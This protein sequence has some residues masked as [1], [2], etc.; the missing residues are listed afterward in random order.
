MQLV[1]I[2]THL[3]EAFEEVKKEVIEMLNSQNTNGF[4][5][6]SY[7]VDGVYKLRRANLTAEQTAYM[8]EF[9]K[10]SAFKNVEVINDD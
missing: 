2:N 6:L 1:Q 3:A 4:L 7:S 10:R 9:I 5:F 8:S